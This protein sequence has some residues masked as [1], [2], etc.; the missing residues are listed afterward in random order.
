[1]GVFLQTCV[2]GPHLRGSCVPYIVPWEDISTPTVAILDLQVGSDMLSLGDCHQ[3]GWA[4]GSLSG[5]QGA[6]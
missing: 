1:M 2:Q 5:G 4:P 3:K 6:V